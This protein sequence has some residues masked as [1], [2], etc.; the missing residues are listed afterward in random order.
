MLTATA[1]NDVTSWPFI[2]HRGNH[3]C[4]TCYF[5]CQLIVCR[6]YGKCVCYW[7]WELMS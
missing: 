5:L 2:S 6:L 7:L 4:L 3:K 1:N